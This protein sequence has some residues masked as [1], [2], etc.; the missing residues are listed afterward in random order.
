MKISSLKNLG[1]L[2]ITVFIINLMTPPPA[3][4]AALIDYEAIDAAMPARLTGEDQYKAPEG[5]ARRGLLR[6]YAPYGYFDSMVLERFS[7]LTGCRVKVESFQT[8]REMLNFFNTGRADGFDIIIFR[9]MVLSHLVQGSHLSALPQ[10]RLAHLNGVGPKFAFLG[11]YHG[12]RFAVPLSWRVMGILNHSGHHERHMEARGWGNLLAPEIHQRAVV[13]PDNPRF[14]FGIALQELG[15]SFDSADHNELAEAAAVIRRVSESPLFLGFV[16]FN[17]A[18]ALCEEGL[19]TIGV[20]S[21]RDA[22]L[23]MRGNPE[24]S[25]YT[26]GARVPATADMI[27]I[28]ADSRNAETA[29][30]FIDYMLRPEIAAQNADYLH[31]STANSLA[32]DL[33][34]PDNRDDRALYPD[35]EPF[36]QMEFLQDPAASHSVFDDYYWRLATGE[37]NVAIY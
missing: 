12:A 17:K 28:G 35:L 27:A 34:S 25:F 23:A 32:L 15:Y 24:L 11:Y 13:L 19:V 21:N 37:H 5:A 16:P 20:T 10:W 9:H 6:I 2:F 18:A 30:Y 26:A 22:S 14:A 36:V 1:I 31:M 8:N 4:P 3:H 29:L 7:A 33:I